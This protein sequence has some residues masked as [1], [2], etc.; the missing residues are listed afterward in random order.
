VGLSGGAAIQD[1]AQQILLIGSGAE[2]CGWIADNRIYFHLDGGRFQIDLSKELIYL[3]AHDSPGYALP[4][5]FM[6]LR[7]LQE[8]CKRGLFVTH[9]QAVC[10]EK[11]AES[12]Q[13]CNELDTI[14]G[15]WVG[16]YGKKLIGKKS[17][18]RR[19]LSCL[20]KYYEELMAG[21]SSEEWEFWDTFCFNLLQERLKLKV[22][23][24][25]LHNAV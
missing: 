9:Q 12:Y 4:T 19:I 1:I 16:L 5:P 14:W 20:M 2:S 25:S 21:T 7:F 17:Q 22:R 8:P 11:T 15:I 13:L 23:I 3:A 10:L 18:H 24:V 6:T